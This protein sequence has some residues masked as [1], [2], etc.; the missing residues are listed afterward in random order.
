MNPVLARN[1][2]KRLLSL[3][4]KSMSFI[5]KNVTADHGDKKQKVTASCRPC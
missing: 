3:L 2:E 1:G 4:P 5:A